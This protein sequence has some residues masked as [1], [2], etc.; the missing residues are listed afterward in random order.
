MLKRAM[1][2]A[3]SSIEDVANQSLVQEKGGVYGGQK[4]RW[5]K[6][7]NFHTAA[8]KVKKGAMQPGVCRSLL[9]SK[10]FYCHE[11]GVIFAQRFPLTESTLSASP[12]VGRYTSKLMLCKDIVK[13]TTAAAASPAF[14]KRKT[15]I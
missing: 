12:R 4:A 1:D 13:P 10:V 3:K 5:W 11:V 15:P 8:V 7:Q 2:T 14:L 6:G 9:V